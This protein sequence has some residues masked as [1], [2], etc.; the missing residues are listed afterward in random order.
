[1][2]NYTLAPE[3][4]TQRHIVAGDP[5][6]RGTDRILIGRSVESGPSRDVWL[7]ITGEQVLAAFGKRGTGKSYTLGVLLEG[8]AA[9]NGDSAIANLKTPRG[10]LVFDIMDI[11]WTSAIPLSKEGTPEIRKQYSKMTQRGLSPQQLS[12]DIWLPRGFENSDIDPAPLHSLTI[13]ASE[14]SLDDWGI[15]FGIDMYGEPRGMLVADLIQRVSRSGYSN[16]QGQTV[17]PKDG[18]SLNDLLACLETDASLVTDYQDQTRRSIRQRLTTYAALPLFN[19]PGTE[20]SALVRPFRAAVLMLGRVPDALKSVIVAVLTRQVL[21]N[22]RDVS[23]ATK[24]LD[25]DPKINDAEKARLTEFVAS[26]LPRTWILMDE[27][28]VLAGNDVSSVAADALVKYAKEGRN[29]GLSLAVATQQPSALNTRL[30][31]QVETLICHQLTS[32]ADATIAAKALRS[33]NPMSIA[34]DG[35]PTDL[36]GLVRRL[37]Q[38]EAI[39]S[40]GNAPNLLRSCVIGVRPRITAHGGYEA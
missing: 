16:D 25:L 12:V 24:R 2:A 33:P 36:E 17:L 22:R 32:P 6:Q 1:M 34:I 31:S 19:I 5:A 28:H 7:D 29:Y 27:A 21:R 35:T 20:L 26:G 30:V 39:F 23:F 4:S 8:L 10:A 13:A 3:P 15:L 40:C 14:L 11:Y 9:G 38:G 18:F 37:S